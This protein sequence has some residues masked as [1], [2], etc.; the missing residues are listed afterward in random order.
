[1]AELA[2]AAVPDA[3]LA[4][5]EADASLDAIEKA[6]S[7]QALINSRVLAQL[8]NAEEGEPV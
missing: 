8:E 4:A 5:I 2:G 1:M 7:R 6:R 3:E